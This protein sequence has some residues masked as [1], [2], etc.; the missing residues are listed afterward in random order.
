M[1]LLQFSLDCSD[2][3]FGAAPE[4]VVNTQSP[5]QDLDFTASFHGANF[6]TNQEHI[7]AARYWGVSP[8]RS[9][10]SGT[11]KYTSATSSYGP[12]MKEVLACWRFAALTVVITARPTAFIGDENAR[13]RSRLPLRE[14]SSA[15]VQASPNQ[16]YRFDQNPAAQAERLR[17]EAR[18]TPPGVRRAQLLRRARQI[19]AA[20]HVQKQPASSGLQ[21]PK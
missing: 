20:S 7:E 5:E 10:S 8:R 21:S 19:E 12:S 14:W 17:K 1:A 9:Q 6:S 11:G 2:E 16:I 3:P 4:L 15:M 18:G 13:S